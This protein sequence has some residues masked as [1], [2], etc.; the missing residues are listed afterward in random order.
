MLRI[1]DFSKVAKVSV[2]ML[3]HYDQI[4]LLKPACIDETSG[5]RSYSIDQLPRLNRIMF[6]KDIGFSLHEIMDLVDD[7]ISVEEMKA[8][9]KKRQKEL[10]NEINLAQLNLKVVMYRLRIIEN[11]S[12]MP[13]YDVTVKRTEGY[14]AVTYRE[15]VPNL[16]EMDTYCHNM[17]SKLYKEL[18]RLNISAI[19]P[20]VCYY[21]HEEYCDTDLDMAVGVIIQ[22][23]IDEHEK[24]NASE[25]A[26]KRVE[27]Q[28]QVA[29]LIYSGPFD[30]MEFAI[31]ELLK[32]IGANNWEIVGEL[33]E[34]HLSGP[35][36]VDGQVQE[37]NVVELQ[38]PIRKQL[39]E[40]VS[41]V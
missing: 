29:S 13:K 8:M 32:W 12:E 17:Y 6:L 3:R 19:G 7:N 16:L 11:E 37:H 15:I 9:L 5:Y 1:G 10:E 23:N 27:A 20:E 40:G 21:Y 25:I 30:G 28:E 24:I 18:K 35:A 31:I 33:T 2:R 39:F 14:L 26:L 22:G 38:I 36:Y 34:V 4:G 41:S